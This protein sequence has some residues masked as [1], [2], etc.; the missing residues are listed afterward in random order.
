MSDQPVDPR[1]HGVLSALLGAAQMDQKTLA[2]TAKVSR[3]YLSEL[4][5]GKKAPSL[6]VATALDDALDGGGRLIDLVTCGVTD[7]ENGAVAAASQDPR[8]VSTEAL[9]ALQSGLAAD[10]DL[11]DMI[12]SA[13]VLAAAA[14]K[15]EVV[16]GLADNV[17]GV[18]RRPVLYVAAQYA[19]FLG[20]LHISVGA[21]PGA[22]TWLD[23]SFEWGTEHGD[24]DLIATAVSYKAHVSWLTHQPGRVV[25]L[26]ETALRD[27]AVHPC[28]RGYDLY[29][30]ARGYA[31]AGEHTTAVRRIEQADEVAAAAIGRTDDRPAWQYYR[32]PWM[33]K[34]ESGLARVTVGR[35]A[36]PDRALL[37]A[38]LDDLRTGLD[39][40]PA[41]L[42]GADW[43][44][45]Y[46]VHTASAAMAVGELD[47]AAEML[48]RADDIAVATRSPRIA[49][50]V[51]DRR[52]RL[53]ADR[54]VAA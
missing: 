45:E 16:T 13:G 28:Q 51:R 10:R 35:F 40:M 24:P 37:L 20:W 44:G 11:D 30:A 36:G 50:M 41:A 23:R 17:A 21:W 14:A 31:V 46:V 12:G 15:G 7:D 32:D 52:L 2:R 34:L 38:G 27:P 29:Q 47:E 43:A 48:A 4:V 54:R 26:A 1:F 42:A 5:N 39:T 6:Q 49:R 9:A 19:Q 3:G 53:G 8:R 25:G 18:H 33:W 22:R